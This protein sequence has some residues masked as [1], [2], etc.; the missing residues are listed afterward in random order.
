MVAGRYCVATPRRP[1][2]NLV[3][4]VKG[5]AKQEQTVFVTIASNLRVALSSA[6]LQQF[7]QRVGGGMLARVGMS[8]NTVCSCFANPSP[9]LPGGN[10]V[11]A[12][13]QHNIDL[14]PCRFHRLVLQPACC[15][16]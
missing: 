11:G 5:F 9:S 7:F 8:P 13:L 3:E 12:A 6:G 16:H 14:R 10:Q 1:D 4:T 2:P 15:A